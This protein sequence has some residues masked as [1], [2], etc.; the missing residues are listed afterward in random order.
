MATALQIIRYQLATDGESPIA[1]FAARR[2]PLPAI[3]DDHDDRR[4]L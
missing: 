3:V 4:A 1:A 2:A